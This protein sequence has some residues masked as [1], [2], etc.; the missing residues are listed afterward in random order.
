M[1]KKLTIIF[2]AVCNVD[3][4]ILKM[5]ESAESPKEKIK[6]RRQKHLSYT[7][8]FRRVFSLTKKNGTILYCQGLCRFY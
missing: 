6:N 1:K 3:E 7:L 2:I 4:E 5:A 8:M